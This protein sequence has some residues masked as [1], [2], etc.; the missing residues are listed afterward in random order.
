MAGQ[1][2]RRILK[3]DTELGLIT[4]VL[5]KPDAEE[6]L[7]NGS[8]TG[9]LKRIR[10]LIGSG[11]ATLGQAVGAT[12][13]LVA[14]SDGVNARAIKT[15]SDGTLL[16]QLTGR[17]VAN[18]PVSTRLTNGA[19]F[20]ASVSGHNDGLCHGGALL[21]I[22]ADSYLSNGATWD[23][24]RNNTEGTLLASAARTVATN[25][26]NQ[27]NYNA[28]GVTLS[29]TV[30]A[31]AA[32]TTLN[33]NLQMIDLVSGAAETIAFATFNANIGSVNILQAYPGT[34]DADFTQ[35]GKSVALPRVWRVSVSPSDANS[36]S[37]SLSYSYTI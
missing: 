12:G 22:V 5:G 20:L 13:L 33:V 31:K 21:T 25:S 3:D 30:T 17:N 10:T 19:D 1:T 2:E 4:D 26:S 16:T 37:Y 14:G 27:I 8:H 28:R 34:I 9:I 29:L 11:I 24:Q 15:A 32:A 35:V 7:E 18:D 6:A 36:V 23:R